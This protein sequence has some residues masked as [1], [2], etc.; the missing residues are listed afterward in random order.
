MYG[1]YLTNSPDAVSE[2][3]SEIFCVMKPLV[4]REGVVKDVKLSEVEIKVL[5]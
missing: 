3:G 4:L 2:V 5:K 1:R